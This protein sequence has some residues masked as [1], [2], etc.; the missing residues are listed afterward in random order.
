M[1]G[2][3][4]VRVDECLDEQAV[5]GGDHHGREVAGVVGVDRVVQ[6]VDEQARHAIAL[7]VVVRGKL[8]AKLWRAGASGE[9]LDVG[10]V[11]GADRVILVERGS[12]RVRQRQGPRPRVGVG[13]ADD[14]VCPLLKGESD[15]FVEER[16]F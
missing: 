9:R 8:I 11:I 4:V 13:G 10:V 12:Q 1:A 15:R 16:L 7:A 2:G 3:R 5:D 6:L 14:R